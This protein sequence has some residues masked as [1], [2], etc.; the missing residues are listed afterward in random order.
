MIDS[1]VESA[2]NATITVRRVTNAVFDAND[3]LDEDASTI[4]TEQVPAIVSSPSTEDMRRLEGRVESASL[5]ATVP[6]STDIATVRSGVKDTVD[7]DGRSYKVADVQEI[8]HPFVTGVQKK[9]VML[10][11]QGGR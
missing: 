7:Y 6:S 1:V 8:T 5:K 2:A 11:Q 3:V 4:E 9:T 10:E